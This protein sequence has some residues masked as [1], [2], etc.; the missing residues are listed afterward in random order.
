L[1]SRRK[2]GSVIAQILP[3]NDS[4]CAGRRLWLVPM[5]RASLSSWCFVSA[6]LTLEVGGFH[7]VL[8]VS[9]FERLTNVT[10]RGPEGRTITGLTPG[11]LLRVARPAATQF[12]LTV[13]VRR[14]VAIAVKKSH[15]GLSF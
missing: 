14:Y 1:L 4:A 6:A 3:E 11:A 15:F 2:K 10:K 8:P 13:V 5:G 7:R 12:T 9:W